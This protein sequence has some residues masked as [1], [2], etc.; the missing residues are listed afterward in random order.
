MQININVDMVVEGLLLFIAFCSVI[1]M[2]GM[3]VFN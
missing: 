2:N 1:I 3:V